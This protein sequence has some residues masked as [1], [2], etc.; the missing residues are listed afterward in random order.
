MKIKKLVV[1][2]SLVL[3][4]GCSSESSQKVETVPFKD[5]Q[6]GVYQV[7]SIKFEIDSKNYVIGV[8]RYGVYNLGK[9]E[10]DF[11]STIKNTP[12]LEIKNDRKVVLHLTRESDI[13]VGY[14]SYS[15]ARAREARNSRWIPTE[16]QLKTKN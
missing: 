3:M 7:S 12:T 16:E 11:K 14:N 13:Y 4:I 1:L 9:P 15:K 8:P 6:E 5:V 10:I 2:S